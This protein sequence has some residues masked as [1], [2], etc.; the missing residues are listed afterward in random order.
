MGATAAIS[1]TTRLS[2]RTAA[3]AL[4]TQEITGSSSS[5]SRGGPVLYHGTSGKPQTV[6]ANYLRM[7]KEKDVSVYEYDVRFSP[8]ID[9][10]RERHNLLDQH[11]DKI[12]NVRVR[13]GSVF[14]VELY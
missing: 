7:E 11:L 3:M 12:G 8:M 10:K 5:D 14:L 2:E 1:D 6:Y 13:T 4:D 9:S